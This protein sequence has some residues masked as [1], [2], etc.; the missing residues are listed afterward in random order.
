M[1]TSKGQERKI[2]IVSLA[3]TKHLPNIDLD[4][5]DDGS[6]SIVDFD[7][8][9]TISTLDEALTQIDLEKESVFLKKC[10]KKQVKEL[11][12]L[13]FAFCVYIVSGMFL[14]FYIEECSGAPKP[15][16]SSYV[17]NDLAVDARYENITASC[18]DLTHIFELAK[19]STGANES[20]CTNVTQASFLEFCRLDLVNASLPVVTKKATEPICHID[21]WTLLKYAEFTIFT[22]LTI[23]INTST[24]YPR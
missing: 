10:I 2:T 21:E 7:D 14:F 12:W 1:T 6:S 19:N 24:V 11:L 18:I 22:C 9:E 20:N 4:H 13:F 23:G 17:H 8:D 3:S 5:A 16:D 15:N